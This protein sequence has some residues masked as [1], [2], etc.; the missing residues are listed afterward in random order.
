MPALLAGSS[1]LDCLLY[2]IKERTVSGTL[3]LAGRCLRPYQTCPARGAR[4]F[5]MAPLVKWDAV[6]VDLYDGDTGGSWWD[7]SL[8]RPCRDEGSGTFGGVDSSE[9]PVGPAVSSETLTPG[10]DVP[11][12]CR[13]VLTVGLCPDVAGPLPAVWDPVV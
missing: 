11:E 12:L 6:L 1:D 2:P 13:S 5:L 8:V 7:V 10:V 3:V 9:G 4:M